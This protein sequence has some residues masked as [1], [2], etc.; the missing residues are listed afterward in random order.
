MP[1]PRRSKASFPRRNK[2]WDE[3]NYYTVNDPSNVIVYDPSEYEVDTG[4]LD[5][6]GNPI[7]YTYGGMMEPIGFIHFPEADTDDDN[8]E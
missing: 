3:D 7:K 4:I 8:E 1:L 5:V 2:G 6:D